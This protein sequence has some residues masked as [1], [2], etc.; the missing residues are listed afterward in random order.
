MSESRD[1]VAEAIARDRRFAI[2]SEAVAVETDLRDNI[3]IRTI[4]AALADDGWR[5]MEELADVSP[6]NKVSIADLLVRIRSH[7]YIRRVLEAVKRRGAAA[8]QAIM[9][10]DQDQDH[11]DNE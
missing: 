7:V 11:G 10:E 4:L 2:L 3:T 5:A 9:S 6:E 1:Y 8:E